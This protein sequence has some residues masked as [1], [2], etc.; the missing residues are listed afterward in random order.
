MSTNSYYQ[1]YESQTPLIF[2]TFDNKL[3]QFRWLGVC[4]FL[5]IVDQFL[6]LAFE[7]LVQTVN[8]YN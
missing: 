6:P 8:I 5:S 2:I 7:I 3:L 1:S 4:S